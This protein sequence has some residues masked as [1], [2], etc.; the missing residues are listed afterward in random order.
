M[1]LEAFGGVATL[2]V[3]CL[4]AWQF[5]RFTLEDVTRTGLATPVLEIPQAPWW[6]VVTVI[7]ALCVP[8]QVMVIVEAVSRAW[9]G[10]PRAVEETAD[11]GV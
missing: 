8:V 1:W 3:F 6:W 11:A 2:F 5:F 10:R 4:F 9:L 7:S